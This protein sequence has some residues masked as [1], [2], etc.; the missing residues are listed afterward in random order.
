[1]ARAVVNAPVLAWCGLEY[2]AVTGGLVI[3]L[4][5]GIVSGLLVARTVGVF[6]RRMIAAGENPSRLAELS[7]KPGAKLLVWLVVGGKGKQSWEQKLARR[8]G[9]PVRVW[10]AALVVLLV[11]RRLGGAAFVGRPRTRAACCSPSW[12][13]RTVRPV[14]VGSPRARPEGRPGSR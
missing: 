7:K 13:A 9:N 11:G 12:S 2:Y 8:V 5:L 1:M 6:R 3:G 10:G 14:D 4:V